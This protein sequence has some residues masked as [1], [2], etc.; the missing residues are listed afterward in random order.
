[1][2]FG[3]PPLLELNRLGG[4]HR[5]LGAALLGLGNRKAFGGL[6]NVESQLGRHLMNRL[7]DAPARVKIH[8]RDDRNHQDRAGG[9]PAAQAGYGQGHELSLKERERGVGKASQKSKVRLKK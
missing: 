7:A 3:A 6:L 9:K 1:M 8:A 4:T 2:Q 5:E